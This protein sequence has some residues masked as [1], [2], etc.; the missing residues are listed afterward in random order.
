MIFLGCIA[1]IGI[2]ALARW[3]EGS[4]HTPGAF[5]ASFWALAAIPACLSNLP[6][7]A[8][9]VFLVVLFSLSC[10]LGSVLGL[11]SAARWAGSD[12]TQSDVFVGRLNELRAIVLLFGLAGLF[13][14]PLLMLSEG[15]SV[16]QLT[17]VS[18]WIEFAA[19]ITVA[20]YREDYNAPVMV[21][22]LM[23]A[24]Y[25]GSL[26]AGLLMRYR[27][28]R[29]DTLV[30][31]VPV[32]AASAMSLATT[33]KATFLL[34]IVLTTGAYIASSFLTERSRT[35][36]R[37]LTN[38]ARWSALGLAVVGMFVGSMV[39]RY[40]SSRP[41]A[42][43]FLADR[44]VTY[45]F[46]HMSALSA[47]LDAQAFAEDELAFGSYTFAGPVAALGFFQRQAGIYAELN[48]NDYTVESNVFTI[49]RGLITD[50]GF[51]GALAA[52]AIAAFV[53]GRAVR[54]IRADRASPIT[55]VPLTV[56]Y[57]VT[58]WSHVVSI[59]TYNS[60]A[61]AVLAYAVVCWVVL[62]PQHANAPTSGRS[63]G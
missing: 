29:L 63:L 49:F 47:W 60:L 34:S 19:E 16:E 1:L 59:F 3:L 8:S 55:L 38:L 32:V 56:F 7:G 35:G 24:T 54:R 37:M 45:A 12:A 9:A 51:A 6:V 62:H 10:V 50:A 14:P 25:I 27:K 22:V 18:A 58:L 36:G 52:T 46:G 57:A 11:G 40:Q 4:W 30:A 20:R 17:S 26:V 13:A 33:A 31:L 44:L 43:A 23:T 15:R 39:M 48:Y 28:S 21:R 2:V 5:F 53:A 61:V 42:V 41:D